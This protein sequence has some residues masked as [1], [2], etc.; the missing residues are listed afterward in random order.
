MNLQRITLD[1]TLSIQLTV[2]GAPFS[3]EIG[4]PFLTFLSY[5]RQGSLKTVQFIDPLYIVQDNQYPGYEP[6][7]AQNIDGQEKNFSNAFP[8]AELLTR[9]KEGLLYFAPQLC[10]EGVNGTY[11]LKDK[12][13]KIIAVF[14]PFDEEGKRSPKHSEDDTE[15]VDRGILEGEGAQREVATYLLDKDHF[16]GVP[17][18]L[19]V[20]LPNFKINGVD[21][22]TKIGSLQEFVENDGASWDIGP[23]D[24]PV[25]EVHKI[26]VL[27]LRIFNNDRH[28]GNILIKDG[29]YG[30]YELVPIDHG[31]ALSPTLEHA[32]FDW[33]MWPQAKQPFDRE[34][35]T[36]IE[37]IDVEANARLLSDLG[38]RP[39]CIKTMKI[40]T[41]FLKKAAAAGLT[42]YDIGSMASRTELDKPSDLETMVQQARDQA[43]E[44]EPTFFEALWG[45]IDNAVSNKA[46]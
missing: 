17:E 1:T 15:L 11:F 45:I 21:V 18:T 10:E 43:P 20:S 5:L 34:T 32:W 35:K 39:E 28:G 41:T 36:Y 16:S 2:N 8:E 24:F 46:L 9:V 26:G 14:K 44:D 40:S 29:P 19:L 13:G 42:L 38:V 22:G 7:Y 27:D 6:N 30:D 33:L 3:V 23:G 37:N 25:H 31:L 12:E 4:H